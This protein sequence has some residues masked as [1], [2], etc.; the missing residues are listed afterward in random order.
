M[1]APRHDDQRSRPKGYAVRIL[2][3]PPRST[4]AATCRIAAITILAASA[5]A[6]GCGASNGTQPRSIAG[7]STV[8][9][10]VRRT[11]PSPTE[12][13]PRAQ[14][15]RCAT[16]GF[17]RPVVK[18]TSTGTP[19]RSVT[20]WQVF[21]SVPVRPGHFPVRGQTLLTLL[22]RAPTRKRA[23]VAG[24]H[25]VNV[26]G[27]TVSLRVAPPGLGSDVAEWETRRARYVAL[28]LNLSVAQ[29]EHFIACMP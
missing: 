3:G 27:R 17:G 4:R 21:Y 16:A 14:L 25:V 28:S 11:T 24:G 26:G 29:L 13:M 23:Q 9:P 19:A 1:P 10:T 20:A 6:A 5:L 12:P 22:E 8:P 18:P 7:P 2:A 15:A